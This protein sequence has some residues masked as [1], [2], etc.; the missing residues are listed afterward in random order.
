[1]HTVYV[2]HSMFNYSYRYVFFRSAYL[3]DQRKRVYKA[4]VII[5]STSS[6]MTRLA[7]VYSSRSYKYSKLALSQSV[8]K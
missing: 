4:E 8:S 1:M 5:F 3:Y 7:M 6:T 2:V